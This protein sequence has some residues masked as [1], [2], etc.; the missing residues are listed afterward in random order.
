MAM[1]LRK[2]PAATAAA[3]AQAATAGG[4]EDESA[5]QSNVAH[6]E[7][8]PLAA[9]A[10]AANEGSGSSAPV[11]EK[12]EPAVTTVP[13]TAGVPVGNEVAAARTTAVARPNAK[14]VTLLEDLKN[15]LPAIEF[16]V[17]PRLTGSNGQIMDAD[18]NKLGE[19]IEVQLISWNDEFCATPGDDSDEAKE[20]VKYSR[21]GTTLDGTGA[22]VADYIKLLQ[23]EGYSKA[24]VKKYTQL[25]CILTDS[26][27]PSEHVGNMV[28]VSLSPQSGKSFQ[29]YQLQESVKVARGKRS[30][31]GVENLVISTQVKSKNNKDF[32]LLNVTGAE[33]PPVA[34]AA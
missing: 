30:A 2:N 3:Q 7:T 27:K 23:T 34:A 14:M 20:K 12:T 13:D 22:S 18:K 8:R 31:D 15:A 33:A 10:T 4:F 26:A 28:L 16:G 29:G 19:Q 11:A 17:L 25:I 1:A 5:P 6:V 24:S 9:A 21:D 32:T